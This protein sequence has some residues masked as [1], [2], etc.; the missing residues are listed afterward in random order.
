MLATSA[1]VAVRL[2]HHGEESLVDKANAEHHFTHDEIA[3]V[4]SYNL[5]SDGSTSVLD[6]GNIAQADVNN[7]ATSYAAPG[8]FARWTVSLADSEISKLD[9]FALVNF[10]PSGLFCNLGLK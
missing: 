2:V 4:Y 7:T 5:H 9:F 6:N 8:P 1:R 10:A 3:T